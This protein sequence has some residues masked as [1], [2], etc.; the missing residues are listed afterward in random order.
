MD[1]EAD[2]V[3]DD[4]VEVA[5]ARLLGASPEV[6]AAAVETVRGHGLLAHGVLYLAVLASAR[7]GADA[8]EA[9]TRFAG[10]QEPPSSWSDYEERTALEEAQEEALGALSRLE[11][12][13]L[14][15]PLSDQVRAAL[16]AY[17]RGAR[18]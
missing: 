10:G 5:I 15:A 11:A 1:E 2:A 7:W 13:D 16:T 4:E 14:P 9:L 12:A 17:A 18:G 8:V 6:A 3:V